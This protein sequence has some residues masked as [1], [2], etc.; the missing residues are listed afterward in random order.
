[1]CA[2][3]SRVFRT[4]LFVNAVMPT[5][6]EL[7]PPVPEKLFKLYAVHTEVMR[8]LLVSAANEAQKFLWATSG[9]LV[10]SE[11]DDSLSGEL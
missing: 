7:E 2:H 8:G 6:N 1:L 4:N 10:Q 11:W 3:A 5:I 9:Y